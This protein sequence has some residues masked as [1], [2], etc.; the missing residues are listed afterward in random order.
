VLGRGEA[1]FAG[2]DL[3]SLGYRTVEHVPT[4]RATHI[5]LAK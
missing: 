3:R 2:L 4:N 5:V 1:L